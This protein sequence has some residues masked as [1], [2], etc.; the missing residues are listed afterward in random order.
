M[1]IL[2]TGAAGFLGLNVLSHAAKTHPA[3]TILAADLGPAFPD[4]HSEFNSKACPFSYVPLDVGDGR[5]CR[6][7]LQSE[8]PTHIVHAAAVTLPDESAL[9][10]QLSS[11]VNLEG[12]NNILQAATVAGSVQRVLLLS[13]SGLYDQSAN[14]TPC[15]EGHPLDLSTAYA[16]TKRQAEMHMADYES[17]GRFPIISARIGPVYGEFEQARATRP[18]VSMIQTLTDH[19]M[20][21]RA[22]V[23]AGTQMHRDWTHASDVA[24]ALDLLLFTPNLNHRIYNVSSGVSVSSQDILDLYIARG[25]I[26]TWVD[27]QKVA[28]LVFTPEQDRKPLVIDRLKQDT[29][30]KPHFDIQRGSAQVITACQRELRKIDT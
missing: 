28:D 3:A 21:E 13:S 9:S 25:L 4:D 18:I 19:L 17:I 2:I 1:R 6:Q 26:A 7:L 30:F 12:T 22:I 24:M 20:A 27:D 14:A 15:D 23:L 16:R 11:S 8:K 10:I 29:G 5:A